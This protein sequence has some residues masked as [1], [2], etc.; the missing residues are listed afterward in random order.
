M[1]SKEEIASIARA[2]GIPSVDGILKRY[3]GYNILLKGDPKLSSRIYRGCQ[4]DIGEDEGP[5]LYVVQ[6]NKPDDH[7]AE[8]IANLYPTVGK[9][10]F[11]KATFGQLG[12]E[13]MVFQPGVIRLGDRVRISE[14]ENSGFNPY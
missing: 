8:Q 5:T 4:I 7:L 9:Q 6:Q 3:L 11:K 13:G 2:L 1:G 10:D 14:P 12:L